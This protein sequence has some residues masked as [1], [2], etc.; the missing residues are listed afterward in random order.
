MY[1]HTKELNYQKYLAYAGL[2]MDSAYKIT[3]LQ[4]PGGPQASILESWLGEGR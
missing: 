3:R 2:A 4:N 1:R